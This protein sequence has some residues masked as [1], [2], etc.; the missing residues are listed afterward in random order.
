MI[1]FFLVI[2]FF[3]YPALGNSTSIDDIN[4]KISSHYSVIEG[5]LFRVFPGLEKIS[6][7]GEIL[8]HGERGNFIFY[9][10]SRNGEIFSGVFFN[11]EKIETKVASFTG[12]EFQVNRFTVAGTVLFFILERFSKEGDSGEVSS[13]KI[14]F[15]C[16]L[17]SQRTQSVNDVDLFRL[18]DGKLL[19]VQGNEVSF[20]GRVMNL[21][22]GSVHRVFSLGGG[23]ILLENSR[24]EF[25]IF[26]TVA[27][28][29]VFF[30]NESL[31]S[32]SS[33][34]P[35]GKN[36]MVTFV[37]AG[38]RKDRFDLGDYVFYSISID[39]R[40]V[41]RTDSGPGDVS[42]EI[43][44]R[45]EEGRITLVKIERWVLNRELKRYV[46]ENNVRQPGVLKLFIPANSEIRLNVLFNG[47][48]YEFR[49]ESHMKK[50]AS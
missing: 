42:K 5:E 28:K 29:N 41:M 2:F 21:E 31:S 10:I 25:Q 37:D 12:D 27:W 50:P 7:S 19:L 9:V 48:S 13:H 40:E 39:G 23:K 49:R 8:A 14:L 33:P 47:D 4:C 46:R 6:L 1:R 44:F 32:K 24:N 18:I 38:K 36:L 20:N 16:D 3:I 15:R 22:I 11:E 43:F 35:A 17:N 45:A 30:F 26:D 34:F